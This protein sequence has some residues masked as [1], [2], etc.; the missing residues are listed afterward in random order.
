MPVS[1]A[2]RV[3]IIE[4]DVD[5]A[6][7]IRK[8]LVNRFGFANVTVTYDGKRAWEELD[9]AASK[10]RPYDLVLSD[11]QMPCFSGIELLKQIRTNLHMRDMR[12][13]MVTGQ[14]EREH[15][16]QAIKAGANAYVTKP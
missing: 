2:I 10:A 8:V 5:V 9:V 4:D 6:E 14:A 7:V 3:L 11:W 1:N 16:L 13:I 12:F 15:V